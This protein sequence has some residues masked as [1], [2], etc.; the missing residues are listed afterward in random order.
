[1]EKCSAG[2]PAPVLQGRR[3]QAQQLKKERLNKIVSYLATNKAFF[4]SFV[5]RHSVISIDDRRSLLSELNKAKQGKVPRCDPSF[6]EKDRR[7]RSS[8]EGVTWHAVVGK[9]GRHDCEQTSVCEWRS[10]EGTIAAVSAV[11]GN[12]L[13]SRCSKDRVRAGE[14]VVLLNVQ[15]IKM[16]CCSTCELEA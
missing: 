3:Q 16:Q 10:P 6:H 7:P 1:M 9:H 5:R 11:Q 14:T 2:K 8:S 15:V 13:A 4:V 12:R